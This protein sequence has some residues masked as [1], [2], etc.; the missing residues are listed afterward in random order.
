MVWRYPTVK[1]LRICSAVFT[2]YRRVAD[3][4][5][6][7]QTDVHSDRQTFFHGIVGA[8]YTRRAVKFG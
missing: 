4:R 1:K 2:E 5:T 6:D 7:R 3:R 8:M